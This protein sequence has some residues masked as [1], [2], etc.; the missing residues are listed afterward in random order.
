MLSVSLY[1]T[2]PSFFHLSH[3]GSLEVWVDF[4]PKVG[5]SINNT[6]S[7]AFDSWNEAPQ[8]CRD[9]GNWNGS[10]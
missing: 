7:A 3:G 1:K 5:L 2:F 10:H 9:A 8:A 4:N 6:L